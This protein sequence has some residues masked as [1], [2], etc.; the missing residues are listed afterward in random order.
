MITIDNIQEVNATGVDPIVLPIT[1]TSGNL[2]LAFVCHYVGSGSAINTPA[3]WTKLTQSTSTDAE[4]VVFGKV[5]DGTEG[6][7]VSITVGSGAAVAVAAKSY[8]ISDWSGDINDI[9]VSTPAEQ[10]SSA[11]I[12]DVDPNAIT[13]SWGADANNLFFTAGYGARGNKP[14]TVSPTGYTSATGY[15]GSYGSGYSAHISTGYKIAN[16][17][18]DDPSIYTA[19]TYQNMVTLGLVVRGAAAAPG[20]LEKPASITGLNSGH[21]LYANIDKFFEFG[22]LDKE[23]VGDTSLSITSAPVVSD[24]DIGDARQ[25]TASSSVTDTF[26][27]D[28]DRTILAIFA[29][30]GTRSYSGDGLQF[31]NLDSTDALRVYYRG[32]GGGYL[33]STFRGSGGS[34]RSLDSDSFG[35]DPAFATGHAYAAHLADTEI[36]KSCLNGTI[37]TLTNTGSSN[38]LSGPVST[39]LLSGAHANDDFSVGAVVVFDKLLSDAELQS[40]TNDPWALLDNTPAVDTTAPVFTVAPA[41]ANIT[42]T[43]CDIT[44][45]I[46]ED[47]TIYAVRLVDGAAAPSSVQ[48]KAGQ[49]STGSAAPEAKSVAAT[50]ATQASMTFSTGSASTPYDYYVVAEDTV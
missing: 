42:T 46:D 28:G 7:T 6:T 32:Y 19:G 21:A 48:V 12:A 41:A 23:L 36:M 16:A 40:V 44:A 45:T 50:A 25:F 4:A 29:G 11:S 38:A 15:S 27:I 24:A 43:G 14:F 35:N 37:G 34:Y 10:S 8:S 2:L 26:N 17:A 30:R 18:T 33:R 13:A 47:G 39:S 22:Q 9:D 31:V 1:A 20:L 49:D 3:G 5:S